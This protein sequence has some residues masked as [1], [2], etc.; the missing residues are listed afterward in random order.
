MYLYIIKITTNNNL[1][2]TVMKPL[3]FTD[4]NEKVV[5]SISIESSLAFTRE[6][7]EEKRSEST[8]ELVD[9]DDFLENVV[10]TTRDNF[11]TYEDAVFIANDAFENL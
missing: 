3:N 4:K 2:I 11:G 5:S 8:S 1:K 6:Q 9:F 7:Y 10:E